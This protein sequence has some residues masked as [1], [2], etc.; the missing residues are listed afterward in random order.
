MHFQTIL[1]IF[2][3]I[4]GETAER[5]IN[6]SNT[7]LVI[8]FNI[9]NIIFA[10][11]GFSK[12]KATVCPCEVFNIGSKYDSE[13]TCEYDGIKDISCK[14]ETNDTLFI[15]VA[16]LYLVA[17]GGIIKLVLTICCLNRMEDVYKISCCWN[18]VIMVLSLIVISDCKKLP[19]GCKCRYSDQSPNDGLYIYIESYEEDL[20][21]NNEFLIWQLITSILILIDFLCIVTS[22]F[23]KNC[24]PSK[25]SALKELK[26]E[27]RV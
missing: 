24:M 25:A 27:A 11:V 26:L 13:S 16:L 23:V 3:N 19:T 9:I 20:K 15:Y 1:D 21:C 2:V 18:C 17:F 12:L 14:P 10:M 5:L 6:D 7:P 8:L 4:F 22:P